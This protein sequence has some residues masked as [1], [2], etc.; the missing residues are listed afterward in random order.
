MKLSHDAIL[1][2]AFGGPT[3]PEE[4]RPFLAHVL[5]GRPVPPDRIESVAH[6]YEVIGGR[7]PINELT[8]KQRDALQAQLRASGVTLPVHVGMRHANPFVGDVLAE[9]AASGARRVLGVIM[10]AFY[11]RATVERYAAA[12][13][14]ALRERSLPLELEYAAGPELHPKLVEANA[15]QIRAAFA[16]LP[17]AQRASAELIFTAHSVPAS[18]GESSGYVGMFESVAERTAS[19]LGVRD[20]RLAYQSRSGSP[21]EVWLEP[22]IC[23]V[24]RER[25]AA[26]VRSVVIA[27]I[28][29]VCDHVEVL[30]D[31]D[32]EAAGVAK[33]LG[34]TL[35]RAST[36]N[37]HSA[38]ITALRDAVLTRLGLPC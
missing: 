14:D 12:V 24:L 25:A 1:M 10:A 20:Y 33:D 22:D 32:V 19:A 3:R 13:S 8:F 37:D 4:I 23:A 26:G 29:F 7:S 28:G 27:P 18:V 5:R 34:I 16:R 21:R 15:E 9:I 35:A 36:V 30:Y 2:I 6:H 17:E 11:D 38:Y 31:L